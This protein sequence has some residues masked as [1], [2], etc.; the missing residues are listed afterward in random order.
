METEARM[1]IQ[2]EIQNKRVLKES[3]FG[4]RLK[5]AREAL[6]LSEK[7]A[8][9]RLHLSPKIISIMENEDSDHSLPATFL[10]GYF[11]TYA[12]LL[13]F[14]ED[15]INNVIVQQE[16]HVPQVA[17][18]GSAPI[19]S[20]RPIHSSHRYMRWMTYAVAIVLIALVCIWWV[21]HP[22]DSAKLIPGFIN[23]QNPE[24]STST[25]S[26]FTQPTNTHPVIGPAVLP[27]SPA[28]VI[29][30]EAT[31]PVLNP[32]ETLDTTPPTITNPNN[33]SLNSSAQPSQNEAAP[34]KNDV[35]EEEYY[36]EDAY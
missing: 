15:E 16:T 19:L 8:A 12:R 24:T 22:K 18:A 5:A 29:N 3:G 4:Q 10:R 23:T 17:I 35:D 13:N 28:P 6:R 9:A 7:D 31:Q 32:L 20:T 25:E 27:V 26:T 1:N 11:R 2:L 34:K 33:P 30:P 21:S 14:T 36:T